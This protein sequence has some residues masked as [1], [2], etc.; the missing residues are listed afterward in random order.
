M[1]DEDALAVARYLKSLEPVRN[2]VK[3]SPNLIFKIG[4][5][6]L[7]RAKE[8]QSFTAP[9]QGPTPEYGSYLAQHVG[10]CGDCHTPRKGLLQKPDRAHL[11]AG[12]SKPPKGFPANPSNLT[13]D[14]ETGIGK[15]SE[16]D[17]IRT[18]R[19]GV[20]PSGIQL[21]PFMPWRE[22]RRMS[23]DDLRAMYRYLRSLAPIRNQVTRRAAAP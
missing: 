3:Q 22:L 16:E 19:T 23:D 4:R 18:M 5:A 8:G 12:T 17:F 6:T 20:N 2:P 21:H 15:W 13:P 10:L 14:A 9:P 1:S 7:L 11:F